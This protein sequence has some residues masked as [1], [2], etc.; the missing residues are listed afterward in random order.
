M[1]NEK[2]DYQE[3]EKARVNSPTVSRTAPLNDSIGP[4]CNHI[5]HFSLLT[6]HL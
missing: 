1:R 4:P 3:A 6:S 2:Y 5:S